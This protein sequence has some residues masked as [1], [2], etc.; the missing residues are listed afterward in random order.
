M[1]EL[2][3][4]LSIID[5]ASEE[6]ERRGARVEA[7]HL[8]L[9]TLSGVVEEALRFSYDLACEGTPLE[10][11]RLVIEGVEAA[12]YCPDCKEERALPSVQHFACSVCGSPT[13]DVTRG[14]E[15]EVAALEIRE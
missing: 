8:R 11:S 13:P 4:A 10:G 2:S 15:L 3:I 12:V 5:M 14:R 1:H 7:V 9:G 6:A